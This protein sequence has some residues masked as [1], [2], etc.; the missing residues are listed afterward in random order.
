M[1]RR[2]FLGASAAFVAGGNVATEPTCE[3][4]VLTA[5]G[6]NGPAQFSAIVGTSMHRALLNFVSHLRVPYTLET[7]HISKPDWLDRHLRS[8]SV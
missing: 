7:K 8:D 3:L 1:N 2:E 5:H 4:A 6:S